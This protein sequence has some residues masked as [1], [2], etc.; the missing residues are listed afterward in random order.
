MLSYLGVAK[1][2]EQH[3][4]DSHEIPFRDPGFDVEQPVFESAMILI[5]ENG[6]RSGCGRQR[7]GLGSF[8]TKSVF[9][10]R[11][12]N[13]RPGHRLGTSRREQIDH[14]R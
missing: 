4:S 8:S 6:G 14:V 12:Q 7:H 5:Q 13:R 1:H 11:R 3:L 10:V 9:L 2:F